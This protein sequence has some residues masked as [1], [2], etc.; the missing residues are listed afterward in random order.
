MT[1]AYPQLREDVI[2]RVRHNDPEHVLFQVGIE[3]H[4]VTQ[5]IVDGAGGFNAGETGA[6]YHHRQRCL[7]L[8]FIRLVVRQLQRINDAVS[9]QNGVAQ[10]LHRERVLFEAGRVIEV[11]HGAESEHE[12][13]IGEIERAGKT[14]VP[15]AHLLLGEIDRLDVGDTHMGVSQHFPQRLNDIGD[16]HVGP[17]DFVEH[18]CKQHEIL[19]R[20]EHDFHV[21]LVRQS[22]LK[23]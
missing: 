23:M 10:G 9:H 16:G 12:L 21:P 17:R 11:R 2:T 13:V 20:Y 7:A 3:L 19:S 22:L 4:R 5:K 14:A 15:D 6:R 8:G 18:R 1:E